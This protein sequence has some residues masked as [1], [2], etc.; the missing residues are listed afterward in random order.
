[1]RK[2]RGDRITIGYVLIDANP[3]KEHEVYNSLT[4]ESRVIELNP[5]FQDD[6]FDLMAKIKIRNHKNLRFYVL[7]N[8]QSLD[9]VRD[10]EIFC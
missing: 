8:I 7:K 9:G 5:I 3:E 4:N 10:T 1:V 6:D 2:N